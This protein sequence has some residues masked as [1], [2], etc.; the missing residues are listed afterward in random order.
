MA[1]V[2]VNPGTKESLEEKTI[3]E[4]FVLCKCQEVIFLSLPESPESQPLTLVILGPL[5]NGPSLSLSYF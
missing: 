4:H 3:T 2:A 5:C 1:F